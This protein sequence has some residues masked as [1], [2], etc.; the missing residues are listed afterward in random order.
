MGTK[1]EIVHQVL[2]E[3]EQQQDVA[4][5]HRVGMGVVN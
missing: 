5:T 4:R 2:V 1:I 3:H